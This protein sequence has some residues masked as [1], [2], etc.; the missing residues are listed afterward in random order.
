[1]ARTHAVEQQPTTGRSYS[2]ILCRTIQTK[3]GQTNATGKNSQSDSADTQ[4]NHKTPHTRATTKGRGL[5]AP[6]SLPRKQ[7]PKAH[8]TLPHA[9]AAQ[10]R[11][12]ARGT[13]NARTQHEHYHWRMVFNHVRLSNI[14]QMVKKKMIPNCPASLANRPRETYA[15]AA[16]QQ[17]YSR[18]NTSAN[19]MTTAQEKHSAGKYAVHSTPLQGKETNTL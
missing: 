3:R 5:P 16:Q 14:Q 19:D 15:Q 13:F 8:K 11:P 7:T 2:P 12:I 17:N 9:P 1:M 10:P 6:K 18:H 4:K